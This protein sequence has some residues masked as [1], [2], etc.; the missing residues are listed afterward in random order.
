[1]ELVLQAIKVR[2]DLKLEMPEK[3]K[4]KCIFKSSRGNDVRK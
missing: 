3:K 2:K 4:Q 1:V